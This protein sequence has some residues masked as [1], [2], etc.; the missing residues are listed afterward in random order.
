LAAEELSAE[1]ELARQKIQEAADPSK[2]LAEER[3]MIDPQ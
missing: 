1:K 2:R 3:A